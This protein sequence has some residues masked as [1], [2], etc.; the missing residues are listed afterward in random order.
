VHHLLAHGHERIAALSQSLEIRTMA[1]RLR[2]YRAAL[3]EAGLPTP[4]GLVRHGL[5]HVE[6]AIA[7]AS[8]LFDHPA[9][10]TAYFGCNNQMTVGILKAMAA[11]GRW[12]AVVGFDD[13]EL[14]EALATPVTVVRPDVRE[15]GRLGAE[16]LLRRM[17]GWSG[18]TQK[19][20]LPIELVPRGSG[21]LQP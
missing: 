5:E 12:A 1:E 21:E 20:V 6:D 3:T 7:A 11:R 18:E 9:A 15:L 16:L 13:F 4:E 14:A 8:D 2:G 17:D 19:V 10:P